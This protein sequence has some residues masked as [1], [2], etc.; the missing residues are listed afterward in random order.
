MYDL[1]ALRAGGGDA[2]FGADTYPVVVRIAHVVYSWWF[3]GSLDPADEE[4]EEAL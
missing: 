2:L 4:Q 3:G 1:Q